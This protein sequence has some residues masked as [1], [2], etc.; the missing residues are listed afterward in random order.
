MID[1]DRE[2]LGP[3]MGIFG[4]DQRPLYTPPGGIPFYVDGAVFDEAYASVTE[5]ADGSTT[6]TVGP[7]LGVRTVLFCDPPAQGGIVY[8]PRTGKTYVV[9]DVRPD[10]HGHAKL[11]MNEAAV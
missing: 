9:R 4:E 7:A 2:V 1:W 3:V 11:L 5:L 6:T 8:V 10:G